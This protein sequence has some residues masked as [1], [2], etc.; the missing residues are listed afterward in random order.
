MLLSAHVTNVLFL[1]W[2]NTFALTT[3]FYWSYT[4]L[5]KLPVLMRSWLGTWVSQW[6]VQ[7]QLYRMGMEFMG[8]R[9][10]DGGVLVLE[11][12]VNQSRTK[13]PYLWQ[14]RIRTGD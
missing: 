2:F 9:T 5:L 6:L 1:V 10:Y 4:L 14:D 13:V 8:M 11:M 7:D 3:G 12:V